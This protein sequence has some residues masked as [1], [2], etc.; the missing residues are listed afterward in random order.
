MASYEQP[1][2]WCVFPLL[3]PNFHQI[4]V[5]T[6]WPTGYAGNGGPPN[7]TQS[8]PAG[9]RA[10]TEPVVPSRTQSENA[11]QKKPARRRVRTVPVTPSPIQSEN[12][13]QN[14]LARRRV[15]TKPLTTDSIQSGNLDAG[16]SYI[17]PGEAIFGGRWP[18]LLGDGENLT[19]HRT[20]DRASG[21]NHIV[22]VRR[23][24][25]LW[26]PC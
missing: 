15:R 10:R 14:K 2:E 21:W 18:R 7:A 6:D 22:R 20:V 17:F 26:C 3:Y 9:R 4:G 5:N 13:T 8:Q 23:N 11:T 19:S 24:G 16:N 25:C 12:A 1:Y